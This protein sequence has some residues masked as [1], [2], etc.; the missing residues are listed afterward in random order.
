MI[1]VQK[2]G[3]YYLT[4]VDKEELNS[5]AWGRSW[6]TVAQL[7]NNMYKIKDIEQ[8]SRIYMNK[9][10]MGCEYNT[11]I[12]NRIKDME[13]HVYSKTANFKH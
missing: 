13:Q 3:Y 12:E 11:D 1:F 6:F 7:N 5:H 10:D 4:D 2:K 9:K 8:M